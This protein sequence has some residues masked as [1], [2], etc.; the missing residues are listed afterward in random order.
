MGHSPLYT[1]ASDNVNLSGIRRAA[2]VTQQVCV[3]A[4]LHSLSAGTDFFEEK[5]SMSS[6]NVRYG[7]TC[8]WDNNSHFLSNLEEFSCGTACCVPNKGIKGANGSYSGPPLHVGKT[9]FGL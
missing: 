2:Q 7:H 6:R 8:E 1:Q 3:V 9:L 5:I 4:L